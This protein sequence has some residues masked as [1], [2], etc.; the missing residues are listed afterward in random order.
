MGFWGL[1]STSYGPLSTNRHPPPPPYTHAHT[2]RP[3]LI[4]MRINVLILF[5]L[6][7]PPPHP[8]FSSVC[9][10][11]IHSLYLCLFSPPFFFLP[12]S[13]SFSLSLSLSLFL[14]IHLSI[15]LSIYL[16]D[17]L[18]YLVHIINCRSVSG[19]LQPIY[20]SL[21]FSLTL[22]HALSLSLSLPTHSICHPAS[23]IYS[24][25]H[26]L[27]LPYTSLSLDPLM[28]TQEGNS[29]LGTIDVIPPPP[30]TH[31]HKH[32]HPHPLYPFPHPPHIPMMIEQAEQI[33]SHRSVWVL[34]FSTTI[35]V[36]P[37]III[38]SIWSL[39]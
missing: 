39:C 11:G 7:L 18:T 29:T 31:T 16:I 4:K 34:F 21:S 33:T 8:F 32:P 35:T 10:A 37:A 23:T 9:I 17:L 27:F 2:I 26:P 14:S 25:T 5:L 12:L 20:L 15:Y 38:S 30:H 19:G 22:P 24:S 28:C 3:P 6:P 1:G 13:L 36:L